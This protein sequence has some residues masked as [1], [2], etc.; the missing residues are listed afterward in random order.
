MGGPDGGDGGRGGD[1]VF[2]VDASTKS[3]CALLGHY[4]ARDG[5]NGCGSYGQG[6]DGKDVII[7]VGG[8]GG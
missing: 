5:S 1:V 4:R 7:K 2:K 6:S 3:L 8:G